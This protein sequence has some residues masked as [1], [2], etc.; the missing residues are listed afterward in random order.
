MARAKSK[1]TDLIVSAR[2]DGQ[3]EYLRAMEN[4]DIIICN[5][6]AGTGKTLMAVG[7]ALQCLIYEPSKYKK[8]VM[9]RPAVTACDEDLGFLPGELE[10]KMAPFVAPMTDSMLF[11]LNNGKVD[12]MLRKGEVE[13]WPIAYMRGRTLNDCVAIFDEAQ[14]STL[15]QMKMFLTRIGRNCKTIIE[16]DVTQSDL[17]GEDKRTNGLLDISRRLQGIDGVSIIK[18]SDSDIVRSKLVSKVL[19]RYEDE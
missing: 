18:L 11:Y 17:K 5:G 1:S 9:V 13:I 2:T 15:N 6:K 16:G 19:E 12:Y 10:D 8:I 3:K 14:N 4:S 7:Y